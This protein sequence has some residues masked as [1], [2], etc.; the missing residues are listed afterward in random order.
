MISR[1]ALAGHSDA[2]SG[3]ERKRKRV[4]GGNSSKE[5]ERPWGNSA[6]HRFF[7]AVFRF[8]DSELGLENWKEN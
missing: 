6:E 5:K 2:S 1:K 7:P 3:K 8:S 4:C